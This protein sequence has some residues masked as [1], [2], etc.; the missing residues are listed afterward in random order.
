MIYGGVFG[1]AGG[2]TKA[3]IE[4][5]LFTKTEVPLMLRPPTLRPDLV[6]LGPAARQCKS[7]RASESRSTWRPAP[8]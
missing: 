7:T 4:G 6:E 8:C 1:A 5:G 3:G 2:V